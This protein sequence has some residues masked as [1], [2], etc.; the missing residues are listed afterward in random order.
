MRISLD[1]LIFSLKT[2]AGG[3]AALFISFALDLER[4]GW[5][6]LTAYIVAQPFA[7]MVQSKALYRVAGTMAGGAFAVL[8]L[9]TLSTTPEILTLILALWLGAC[10]FCALINRTAASY[11]FMLAGYTAAIICFPSVEDPG[12]IF[13]TAVAR[14]EEITLGILCALLA[15]QLFFPQ[16]SGAALQQR[17]QAW[18]ADAARWCA[19]TLRG[20]NSISRSVERD[21]LLSDSLA[22]NALREHAMFDSPAL[23]NAQAWF[24]E[25]QRRM[26]GLMAVLVSIEDRMMML[27]ETRPDLLAEIKP[28]L[29]RTA[30]YIEVQKDDPP[31]R[32]ALLRAIDGAAYP[33]AR[34]AADGDLLVFNTLAARLKDLIRTHDETRDLLR[35]VRKGKRA[36]ITARPLALHADHLMALLGASAAAVAII[37]CNVFWIM[38]AWPSGAGAVI[39]AGVICALFGAADNPSA[40]A[41]KFLSGTVLGV[42]IAA[43]YVVVLLPAIDGAPLLLIGALALFYLPSGIL[44][45]MPARAAGILPAILGFTAT[46]GLQNTEHLAF[47]DFINEAIA[48]VMGIGVASSILRLA[49]AF[50]V[51][52]SIQRLLDATRRDLAFIAAGNLDRDTFESRMFDRLNTLQARRQAGVSATDETLRGAL[53]SL[54]VGLNLFLLME[55]EGELPAEAGQATRQARAEIAKL[56]R[57]RRPQAVQLQVATGALAAAI[58]TLGKSAPSPMATQALM[59]LGG[60]RLLLLGHADFFAKPAAQ[61]PLPSSGLSGATA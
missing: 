46:V 58:T 45:G 18:T 7:G 33:T 41:L 13:E 42:A 2:F 3:M 14:C 44:L 4:P 27:G 15:N 22:I 47:A 32:D 20:E 40:L 23:R 31:T 57:Q 6:L 53:A 10:V 24:V 5:A 11:A 17:L 21:R 35:R 19:D 30:A 59:A 29:E 12:S 50:G 26:Q 1:E 8:A 39:Q 61:L 52:F 56:L 48:L 9:G 16:H 37:L 28:L 60:A 54:R 55:A 38:T 25:L 51:D 34:M 36:P 43:I 49:R